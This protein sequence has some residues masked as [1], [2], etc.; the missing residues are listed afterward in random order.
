MRVSLSLTCAHS[1]KPRTHNTERTR[2]TVPFFWKDIV[3]IGTPKHTPCT[4]NTQC[5]TLQ[6]IRWRCIHTPMHALTHTHTPHTSCWVHG[7]FMNPT[8][9]LLSSWGVHESNKD[10]AE[11]MGVHESNEDTAEFKNPT[12]TCRDRTWPQQCTQK[13][14]VYCLKFNQGLPQAHTVCT[15]AARYV[16]CVAMNSKMRRT[17]PQ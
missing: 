12:K 13:V 17:Q 7:V 14:K 9:T 8:K 11:F 6:R 2:F 10:A 3:C 1:H 4:Q 15:Q 5:A 16:Y